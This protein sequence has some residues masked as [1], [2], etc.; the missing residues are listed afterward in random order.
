[1]SMP[2]RCL[3]QLLFAAACVACQRDTPETADTGAA[4]AATSEAA[5]ARAPRAPGSTATAFPEADDV[6]SSVPNPIELPPS[7]AATPAMA[8][9]ADM[10]YTCEDGS[11]LRVVYAD[12]RAKVTLPDGRTVSLPRAARASGQAGG[13][14]FVAGAVALHRLGNVVELEQQPGG[15]RRCRESGGSA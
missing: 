14:I 4:A 15:I 3:L 7:D 5:D 13:E 6:L 11:E 10:I 12:T 1:M 8:E 2:P 9:G